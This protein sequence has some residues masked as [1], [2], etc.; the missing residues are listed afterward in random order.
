MT[1]D[2]KEKI[3]LA[4]SEIR[5][6]KSLYNEFGNFSYR[7]A[8]QILETA[9]PV[10]MKYGLLLT[11]NDDIV[12]VG[13]R[14]YVKAVCSITDGTDTLE[15]KSFAREPETLKG[16]CEAQVTG[17][18]SSYARKYALNAILLLDDAK[19]VDSLDNTPKKA[20]EIRTTNLEQLRQF[21]G[22]MKSVEGVDVKELTK[23]FKYYS[24][25]SNTDAD[26]SVADSFNVWN[27]QKR[28]EKWCENKRA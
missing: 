22:K 27:S 20:Q 5:A 19:D 8:E 3:I 16:M 23:F 15:T 17:S 10:L 9:K 7:S 12:E 28:W 26:K 2:F 13:G 18:A 24:K 6:N 25:P 21:C 4:Q 11:L 1:E 14:V